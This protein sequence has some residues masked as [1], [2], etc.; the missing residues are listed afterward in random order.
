MI[1]IKKMKLDNDNLKPISWNENRIVLVHFSAEV[2][3]PTVSNQ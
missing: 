1:M 2:D 3:T